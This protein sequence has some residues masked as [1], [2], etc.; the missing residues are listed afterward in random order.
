LIAVVALVSISLLSACASSRYE[1]GVYAAEMPE[2]EESGW[3]EVMEVTI[4]DGEITKVDWDA[5]YKDESI[6]IRKKQYSKSGLYGMLQGGA[7][8][9]W[10]DQAVAAEQ[11]VLENWIDALSMTADGHTDAVSGCT[12]SVSAFEQL[13]RECLQQ[14]EK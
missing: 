10:Y 1:D 6:P 5:I 7:H 2:F 9:E 3:K 13:L 14:A 8:E 11:F 4:E 12:I